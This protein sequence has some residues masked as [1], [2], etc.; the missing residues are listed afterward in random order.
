MLMIPNCMLMIP[1]WLI[2]SQQS[3]WISEPIKQPP[4]PLP[5]PRGHS[6]TAQW[7]PETMV[8]TESYIYYVFSYSYVYFHLKEM[9]SS[10][11]VAYPDC[12]HHRS[13]D[14]RPSLSEMRAACTQALHYRHSG[15]DNPDG[16]EVANRQEAMQHGDAGQKDDSC[17]GWDKAG[18]CEIS[19]CHSE[20]RAI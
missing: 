9:L 13:G 16:C 8:G 19:A 1:K 3:A 7:M 14:L 18:W 17:P 10:C 20:W 12:Q 6:K 15:S 4:P 5:H 2:P 11:S